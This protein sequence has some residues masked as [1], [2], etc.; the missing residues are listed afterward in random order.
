MNRRQLEFFR[1]VVELGSVSAAAAHLSVT[2]P[3][4]SKQ[5]TRLESELS[6]RL[7]RRTP[8]GMVPTSAGD[9]LSRMGGD[10]LNRFE[11]I[12]DTLA[13]RFSGKP[14]FQVACPP[15]TAFV[16]LSPFMV[17]CDPPIADLIMVPAADVD[18]RLEQGVDMAVSTLRPPDDRHGIVVGTLPIMVQAPPATLHE[19]FG[20]AAVADLEYVLEDLLLV[21]VTGVHVVFREA[22]ADFEVPP[23]VQNV[24]T[25]LVGQALAANGHG[26]ALATEPASFGL[27]FLP[28]HVRHAPI[29]SKIYASWDPQ[30]YAAAQLRE[31]AMAFKQWLAT[32]MP[33]SPG[34]AR[35]RRPLSG[36]PSDDRPRGPRSM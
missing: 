34:L 4:V 13:S 36:V 20:D 33:T 24:A 11:R 3:A 31:T 17:D 25:G 29:G 5:I 9:A 16:L 35:V 12:E 26:L 14:V 27:S 6:L 30:H 32:T 10:L 18:S 15:T 2:Q 23:R 19:R 7:F 8:G 28:A 21:P 22:T 1:A